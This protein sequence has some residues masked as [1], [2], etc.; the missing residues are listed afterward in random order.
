METIKLDSLQVEDVDALQKAQ[1]SLQTKE[2]NLCHYA[3]DLRRQFLFPVA[4]NGIGKILVVGFQT[5]IEEHRNSTACSGA[6]RT[7]FNK[8]LNKITNLTEADCTFTYAVKCTGEDAAKAKTLELRNCSRYLMQEIRLVDPTVIVFLGKDAAKSIIDNKTRSKQPVGVPFKYKIL[9]HERWCYFMLNPIMALTKTSAVPVVEAHFKGLASLLEK[10]T[11][12][13]EKITKPAPSNIQEVVDREYILVNTEEKLQE[14]YTDLKQYK[15][16]GAD[17]ETNSL[18]I[19]SNTF[20]VVGVSLA[21]DD[22]IGYYI[23]FGH[24]SN[25][26]RPYVQLDWATVKSVLEKLLLDP[27]IQ[28]I[29][30]NLYYD[31]AAL[32]Q[33]GLNIFKLD[34]TKDIWTH[35]SMLMSYLHNENPQIGLKFQMYMHFNISPQTFKGV[36][37]DA[38]VNTFEN[39]DPKEAVKY[40]A[41]DAINCLI[42]FKKLAPL[43]K[44]ESTKYTNNKLLSGIYPTELNTIK[45]LA[46]AH[47]KGI[48]VDEQYLNDLTEVVNEDLK[49]T[50]KEIYSISTIVS[51]LSSNPRLVE[52]LESVLSPEFKKRFLLKFSKLNAQEKTLKIL[53]LGYSK[54]W[55][56]PGTKPGK[57]E[58]AK[59]EKYLKLIIRYR[60]LLKMK[61]TYIDALTKLKQQDSNKDWLIHANI[62]SIGT[63]SGRMSSNNPNLQ[64]IPRAVPKAP[65]ECAACNNIFRDDSG[66]L[67]GTFTSDSTLSRYTCTRCKH[68]TKTYKYDLR[69]LYIPRKGMKFIA[70]DYINMEL[71]LAAAVSG[72]K[73]L[74]DVFLKKEEDPTDPAGD[75]HV[76]TASSILGITP[77]KWKKLSE[78]SKEKEK[79]KAKEARTIAK[80]VNF[81]TLYGG[82]P[83]GLHKTF[84]A[85]GM[86]KTVGECEEYIDAFFEAFPAVK[87]WFEEQKY[88][89]QNSGRL[90]NNYGRIRHVLK[91]GGESLSAINMLIQGLGAQIIKESL[92]NISKEWNTTAYPLLTIHDEN[93]IEVEDSQL[94]TIADRLKE[95]MEIT[96]EDKLA[97][98]LRTDAIIGM[99]SLSKADKGIT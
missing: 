86:D 96:V 28:T 93:I 61:S 41:D 48:R 37:E 21:G 34:P 80:T 99:N 74:Y 44:E 58:P 90:I 57:W 89:I 83:D 43:V 13:Y 87:V 97:V 6:F 19:W 52:F 26:R 22:K 73:E 46:D 94:H 50:E 47:L 36:L 91:K 12:I 42:L 23:P 25:T 85:M 30:H 27:K 82:S 60:H 75:M 29:W 4:S 78:S 84:M 35:D 63:T 77:Q 40:A 15:Y 69:R 76:V 62:K 3:Q 45:V 1:A 2:C 20:T 95:I 65:I 64:N 72:C 67:N 49:E 11:S 32:Q 68:V 17:T 38:D 51:N 53:T 18:K 8:Y 24:K 5:F 71:Y 98:H 55:D 31:Y 81:L 54:Y 79:N 39:V 14:M 59:L 10:E 92:V 33:M 66:L 7:V 70:A 9:G 16:I 56:L 88:N